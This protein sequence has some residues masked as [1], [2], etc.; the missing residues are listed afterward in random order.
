V[1]EL[2][3]TKTSAKMEEAPT[4]L[5][6]VERISEFLMADINFQMDLGLLVS[7]CKKATGQG[8]RL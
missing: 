8:C 2:I 7:F 6:S 4:Y 5:E 1:E 3:L